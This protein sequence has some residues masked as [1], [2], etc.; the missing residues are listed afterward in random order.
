MDE[1]HPG[2]YPVETAPAYPEYP[3]EKTWV[4]WVAIPEDLSPATDEELASSADAKRLLD[5]MSK[6]SDT[7]IL[8]SWREVEKFKFCRGGFV[9]SITIDLEMEQVV[10]TSR[11][12]RFYREVIN[13]VVASRCKL[14]K[15]ERPLLVSP[16]YNFLLSVI[17]RRSVCK[18]LQ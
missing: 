5:I 16:Q 6:I 12:Y 4:E 14:E 13:D 15:R 11:S 9:Q 10:L 17:E 2:D 7:M 18:T 3:T 1:Y 8:P